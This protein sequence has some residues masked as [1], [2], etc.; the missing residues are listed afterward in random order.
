MYRNADVRSK[1][2][3]VAVQEFTTRSAKRGYYDVVKYFTTS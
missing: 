1:D 3:K 2:I